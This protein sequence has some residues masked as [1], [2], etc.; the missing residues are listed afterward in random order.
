M[1]KLLDQNVE[2]I[3]TNEPEMLFDLVRER[4]NNDREN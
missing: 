2:C 3:T 4:E 1:K